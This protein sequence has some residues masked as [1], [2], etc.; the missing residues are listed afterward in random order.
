MAKGVIHQKHTIPLE[1]SWS[2][3][4]DGFVVPEGVSLMDPKVVSAI[5]CNY[6]ALKQDCYAQYDKDLW[7]LMEDFDVMSARALAEYP[8]YERIVEYK[9][10]GMQN[11]DI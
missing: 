1:E 3:D 9:I 2:F 7:F 10:D 4:E 6:S 11:V 8:M 5:L